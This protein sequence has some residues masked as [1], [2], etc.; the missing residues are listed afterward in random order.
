M[1]VLRAPVRKW[2]ARSMNSGQ[3]RAKRGA[4]PRGIESAWD[5][6]VLAMA[7]VRANWRGI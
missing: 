2:R 1:K 3:V 4:R 6:Q 5:I 7:L